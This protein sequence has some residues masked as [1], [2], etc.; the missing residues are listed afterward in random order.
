L[1]LHPQGP[2]LIH[3]RR[4]ERE[5]AQ[6]LVAQL[7]RLDPADQIGAGVVRALLRQSEGAP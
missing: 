7:D 3:L 1:A 6:A 4:G 2:G 5:L